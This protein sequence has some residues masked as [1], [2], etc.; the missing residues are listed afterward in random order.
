[1]TTPGDARADACTCPP[2]RD[3]VDAVLQARDLD[4]CPAH[5]PE[6]P[7]PTPAI[8]LNDD[9]GLLQAISHAVRAPVTQATSTET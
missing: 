4:P 6:T 7:E 5:R 3:L 1:M 2:V 8:A 9:G